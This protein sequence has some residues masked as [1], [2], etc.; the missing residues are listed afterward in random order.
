MPT[1]TARQYDEIYILDDFYEISRRIVRCGEAATVSVTPR[2]PHR[3][4]EFLLRQGDISIQASHMDGVS[5]LDGRPYC[6]KDDFDVLP[7]EITGNTLTVTIPPIADEGMISIVFVHDESGKPRELFTLELF[8]LREDLYRLRPY[9]GDFHLHSCYSA[10]GKRYE[11]PCYVVSVGRAAGLD[12]IAVTDHCQIHGSEAALKYAARFET[13]YRIFPG[14][15]CH[16]PKKK[17]EDLFRVTGNYPW[18]HIVN[19]GGREGVCRW[20]AEHWDEYCAE[21]DRRMTDY[22]ADWHEDLRRLAAVTSFT[23][24]KIH[25]FGGIAVFS[26][27]FWITAHRL[28]LPRP[29]REKMLEEGKFDVI[30]VPGLWKYFKPDLVDGN[31]L[32]DAMWHEASIKAGRLLPIAG[33]TDSHEAKAALGSNTTV[34]FASDG[35]FDGIAAALRSGNSATVTAIPG[36]VPTFTCHGSE[37]LVAYTQFL[38]RNF[39]PIHDEYCRTEGN[40]MLALLRDEVTADEV[41]AYG[42]GRLEKLFRKFF[43]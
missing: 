20:I 38:L 13:D 30:E 39:Y 11:D 24:D 32:A 26:H 8:A 29:V 33:I 10:C 22:P 6:G 17:N 34:V 12:F 31:N 2:H 28:N 27:P 19:F 14:E 5:M 43:G 40:L 37:R 25:E 3:A 35:S 23:F 18:M 4:W 36:R 15:E 21:I 42:R 16:M 9:R 7:F 41:N 1:I